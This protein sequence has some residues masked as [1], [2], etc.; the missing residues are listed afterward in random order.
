M[1]S[2]SCTIALPVD[3][4]REPGRK[5]ERRSV[6]LRRIGLLIIATTLIAP[7]PVRALG[8]GPPAGDELRQQTR[9]L[10]RSPA[11]DR[12]RSAR[13]GGVGTGGGT[14]L[15]SRKRL[16]TLYGAP[17]LT[18][19]ILGKL[20]PN[21]AARKV[22]KQAKP[23]ARLSDRRIVPGFDLIAVVA[24]STPGPD[25]K[26]RTRQPGEL[27][28]TYLKAIRKVDGRLVLDVQPGR[29]TT[30]K[31]LRWLEPWLEQPDVDIAIDPEWNVGPKGVPGRTTGSIKASEINEVSRRIQA[32][33][34]EGDLPD[35][36][37]VIHQFQRGSIRKRKRVRQRRNVNV[38]LSFDGIGSPAAKK[39][40]Y[41]ALTGDAIYSGF[42][43]F[44]SLDTRIMSPES[45]LRLRPDVD[46]LLFQ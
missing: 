19:T 9:E 43:I 38:T 7:A 44:Y 27:L 39:A 35:K 45:V 42:S 13:G 3:G 24:N 17:Q 20:G 37:L 12:G 30:L 1:A 29:S 6:R 16:L 23:Y 32:I 36:A 15:L 11:F 4:G 10:L 2:N 41:R 25:R 5:R 26:Y 34:D 18:A 40:G 8:D 14:A 46:F 21:R 22:V 28:D 33:V 31:E